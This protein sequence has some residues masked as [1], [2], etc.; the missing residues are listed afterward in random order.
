[1]FVPFGGVSPERAP[2]VRTR[3]EQGAFVPTRSFASKV[4]AAETATGAHIVSSTVIEPE[5][6]DPLAVERAALTPADNTAVFMS[7]QNSFFK[8]M[9]AYNW[10]TCGS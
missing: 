6:A 9:P 8:S 4:T 5:P 3:T 1:M 7:T 10:P 2:F